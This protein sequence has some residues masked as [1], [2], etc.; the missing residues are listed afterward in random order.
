MKNLEPLLKETED[1]FYFVKDNEVKKDDKNKKTEIIITS[2]IGVIILWLMWYSLY[3]FYVGFVHYDEGHKKTE[4][5]SNTEEEISSNSALVQELYGYIDAK[6]NNELSN[7][8][9]IYN[10]GNITSSNIS[11]SQKLTVVFKYLGLSCNGN[12]IVKSLDELKSA[13]IKIF[14]DDSFV[15]LVTKNNEASF[16]QYSVSY[17][18]ESNTYTIKLNSCVTSNDFTFKS[19]LKATQTENEIYI[20]EAFGYFVNKENNQYDVYD[21]ALRTNKLGEYVDANGNKEFSE[22][23][24]LKKYKWTFK[25]SSDNNYYFVSV[26]PSI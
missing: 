17:N 19:L 12:E 20:Y 16:D 22:V 4:E 2:V 3:P 14:N 15:D 9:T 8:F 11:D 1:K 21:N 7:L 18:I 5:V 6:N 25:K 10:N 23:N 13:A 24:Q 26:T